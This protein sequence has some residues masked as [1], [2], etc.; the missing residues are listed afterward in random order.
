MR[1][2]ESAIFPIFNLFRLTAFAIGLGAS[3]CLNAQAVTADWAATNPSLMVGT[4][5]ISQT[6]AGV[7]I[8][9]RAYTVEFNGPNNTTIYG[10]YPTT[11]GVSGLQVFGTAASGLAGQPGLG[12]LSQP[13]PGIPVSG[14]DFGGG[15]YAPG[16]D[17]GINDRGYLGDNPGIAG[18]P[19]P[20]LEFALFSFSSPVNISAVVADDVGNNARAI[21]AAGGS[22]TP[23]L[24]GGLQAAFAGFSVV[25]SPDVAGDGP[26]VHTVALTSVSYLAV[27]APIPDG[28]GS[29]DPFASSGGDDHFYIARFALA[30]VPE[31]AS[32]AMM[33]AGLVLLGLLFRRKRRLD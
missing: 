18:E 13:L 17:N 6:V 15:G 29:F 3:T 14:L 32:I 9:A 28:I 16:F 1:V 30:P 12:L 26:L 25:N 7:T 19:L 20:K 22:S 10:P 23:N 4:D 8:T 5:F 27:G 31:P 24:A 2:I 11:T 21:W 33:I